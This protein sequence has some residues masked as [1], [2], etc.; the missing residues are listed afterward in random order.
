MVGDLG[1]FVGQDLRKQFMYGPQKL[2]YGPQKLAEGD[3]VA[4]EIAFETVSFTDDI[5]GETKTFQFNPELITHL[6]VQ[7]V[8]GRKEWVLQM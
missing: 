5:T 2:A 3:S 1:N 6:T 7:D 4:E 8:C